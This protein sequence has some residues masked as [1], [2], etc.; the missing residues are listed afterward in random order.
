[1]RDAVGSGE[2]DAMGYWLLKSEPDTYSIEDLERE[3]TAHWEGVRNYQARNNLRAM[4]EGDLAF[5]YHS[6]CA[7]PGIAGECEVVREAYPDHTAWVESSPYFDP[8]STP[9]RPLWFMPDV[10]FVA[11]YPRVVPLSELREIPELE[12]MVLLQKGSRL[13]VQP[14]TPEEWKLIKELAGA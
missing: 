7:V 13:S 12:G 5:F 14:V 4:R 11:R 2:N 8:R 10:R 6:S 9:D 3:G 1:M